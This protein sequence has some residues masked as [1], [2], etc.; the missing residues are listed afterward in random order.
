MNLQIPILISGGGL[1]FYADRRFPLLGYI[2]TIFLFLWGLVALSFT[3]KQMI[4]YI[5]AFITFLIFKFHLGKN[6]QTQAKHT[7]INGEQEGGKLTGWVQ[8][9]FSILLGSFLFFIA[10]ILSSAKGQIM[11][12]VPLALTSTHNFLDWLTLQFSPLISGTLGRIE[13]ALFITLLIILVK[14][15]QTGTLAAFLENGSA[16]IAGIPYVGQI[17][18]I[19]FLIINFILAAFGFM[20]PFAIVCF[21]F[22]MFHIM[23]Y[24]LA[25]SIIIWAMLMMGLMI[26]TYYITGE[27]MTAMDFFHFAWN[28]TLTTKESLSI[29]F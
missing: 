16:F 4:F 6:L 29:A 9:M 10:W 26:A 17:L 24:A 1:L 20:L 12:V 15:F 7:D 19:P 18:Y 5:V 11:G 22:G 25:W 13:N 14:S 28:G 3:E 21:V 27:D 23:A 2:A 8:D